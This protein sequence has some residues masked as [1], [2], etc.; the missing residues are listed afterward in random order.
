LG[1]CEEA[2]SPDGLMPKDGPTTALKM[3]SAF[4]KD[5][6]SK[7]IDL[8]KTYTNFFVAKANQKFK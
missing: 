6:T 7:S 2:I 1:W 8:N 5:I 4:E 3:L